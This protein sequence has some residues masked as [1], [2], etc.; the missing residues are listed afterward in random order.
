ML[1]HMPL[2]IHAAAFVLM[3]TV[4]NWMFYK[5]R[6]PVTRWRITNNAV[7]CQGLVISIDVNCLACVLGS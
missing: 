3:Q 4:L 5:I 1:F 7:G 2:P 6:K